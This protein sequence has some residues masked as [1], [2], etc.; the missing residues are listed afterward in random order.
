MIVG[1]ASVAWA[2]APAPLTTLPAI[3]VLSNE[4][5]SH[6]LP[7]AFEATVTY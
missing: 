6:A 5:A 7:V 3:H 4:Q 1:W 2:A